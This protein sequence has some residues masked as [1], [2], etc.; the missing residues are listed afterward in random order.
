MKFSAKKL[1]FVVSSGKNEISQ[2]LT[3]PNKYFDYLE[4][5]FHPTG[6]NLSDAHADRVY[7]T[8]SVCLSNRLTAT[9]WASAGDGKRGI[10]TPLG[11][12][13]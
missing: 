11:N 2:L 5:Y 7:F 1:V 13:D 12:W 10:Y 8:D 4:Q 9:S 6:K 3:T